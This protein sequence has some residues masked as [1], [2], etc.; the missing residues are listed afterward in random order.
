MA[1]MWA[2]KRRGVAWSDYGYDLCMSTSRKRRRFNDDS[3]ESTPCSYHKEDILGDAKRDPV[4]DADYTL[5]LR[6][7]NVDDESDGEEEYDTDPDYKRFLDHLKADE[8]SYIYEMKDEGGKSVSVKYEWWDESLN[9]TENGQIP[10]HNTSSQKKKGYMPNEMESE[11]YSPAVYQPFYPDN[12]DDMNSYPW[13]ESYA[14]FLSKLRQNGESMILEYGDDVV[15]YESDDKGGTDSEVELDGDDDVR[16][17]SDD[18]G[19]TDSEE[20]PKYAPH[21]GRQEFRRSLFPD[22]LDSSMDEDDCSCIDSLGDSSFSQYRERLM[23][24]LRMPYSYREYRDLKHLACTNKRLEKTRDL[25]GR[26][27]SYQT[28]ETSLSYF[29]Y[30]DDFKRVFTSVR[31]PHH[32]LIRLN[33]LRGFF[34]HIQNLSHEGSFKPWLDSECLKI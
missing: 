24:L 8:K 1:P 32:R 12:K 31:G 2:N 26:L 20:E 22:S 6:L 17:D 13:D 33:L 15:R 19:E 10:V 18:K 11:P 4:P 5:F 9:E 23:H 34:Y 7:L 28:D 29:D 16:S 25:R 21:C 3:L 14:L 27:V 30:Y